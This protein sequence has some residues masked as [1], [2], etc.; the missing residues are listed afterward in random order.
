MLNLSRE[1]R[2]ISALNSQ[3]ASRSTI[4][5]HMC[6]CIRLQQYMPVCRD[7]HKYAIQMGNPTVSLWGNQWHGSNV[8]IQPKWVILQAYGGPTSKPATM[9]AS[10]P[11]PYTVTFQTVGIQ[12]A[13]V[14]P[15]WCFKPRGVVVSWSVLCDAPHHKDAIPHLSIS[16]QYHRIQSINQSINQLINQ[17]INQLISQSIS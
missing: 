7:H 13:L 2:I 17:S 6:I 5:T 1:W 16:H 8:S 11:D 9:G 15:L 12:S 3:Y 10:C 4:Y 14:C